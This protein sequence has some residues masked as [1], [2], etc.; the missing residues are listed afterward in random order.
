MDPDFLD[1]SAT[2]KDNINM[3]KN[4]LHYNGFLA[5]ESKMRR[6]LFIVLL[7]L[8]FSG[9][10]ALPVAGR[11]PKPEAAKSEYDLGVFPF[12]SPAITEKVFAPI[13]AELGQALGRPIHMYSASTFEVFTDRLRL[14]KYDIAHV[15][16]FD[17]VRI[18]APAGYLPIATRNEKLSILFVVLDDSPARSA[19]DLKGKTIGI[20]SRLSAADFLA[21]ITLYQS[22]IHPGKDVTLKYFSDHLSCLQQLHIGTIISC[23]T[24]SAMVRVFEA[25]KHVKLRML[26]QSPKVPHSLFVVHSRV[27]Q[28]DRDMIA[29]TILT[30]TLSNVPQDLRTGIFVEKDGTYFKPV[31]DAD[32]DIVR[33][34]LDHMEKE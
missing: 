10:P 8:C 18:A 1:F 29:R 14:R 13:A 22:G 4:H 19:P 23:A 9:T 6:L 7:V 32:Y 24:S 34:Y 28:K 12:L 30:S 21:R 16:P 15:H 31:K 27:P 5:W 26:M 20:A 33:T 25:Q 17:Y 2:V 3:M 11:E